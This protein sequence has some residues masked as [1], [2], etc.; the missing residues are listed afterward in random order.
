MR[1]PPLD[2]DIASLRYQPGQPISVV[3]NCH[4]KAASLP[5]VITALARGIVR[6]D[7][8]VLS[9]DQSTDGSIEKFLKLCEQYQL[10]CKVVPHPDTGVPFRLNTLR[11]DGIAACPDGLVVILDADLVLARTGLQRH[12]ELH[13]EHTAP[14][15]STGPR[16]EY[17]RSD[18]TGAVNFL[19]GFEGVGHISSPAVGTLPRLPNWQVTSGSLSAMTKRAV[20]DVGWF[21]PRYD[22]NYGF[23]DVDFTYRAELA[24]YQF[25]GDWEAH[26]LHIP[27]PAALARDNSANRQK[28]IQ[29]YGF[30][31]VYPEAILRMCRKPW[32]EYYLEMAKAPSTPET[33][34][35]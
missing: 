19:W 26:A 20:E 9:D 25:V 8:I 32:S 33:A 10:T 22:G 31:L 4:N 1:S 15:I 11:N 5:F 34:K 18:C 16:L 13:C 24:G 7:L 29:K 2:R 3:L 28:F 12:Q 30:D 21:D 27:H 14:I 17:A 35:P 6:P 23:D